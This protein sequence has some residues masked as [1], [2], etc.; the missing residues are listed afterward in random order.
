MKNV[1]VRT[2]AGPQELTIDDYGFGI[3]DQAAREAFTQGQCHALAREINRMTGWEMVGIGDSPD[4]PA[5]VV[6]LCPQLG[7]YVDIYGAT[8]LDDLIQRSGWYRDGI[9]AP[10]L[11]PRQI[12]SLRGYIAPNLRAAAPFAKTVLLE[13]IN[14]EL[15]AKGFPKI[16]LDI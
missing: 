9:T 15:Q 14:P 11:T 6:T 2:Q 10:H 8:W 3:I 7:K 16:S 4:S 13:K 5:H 1:N 12:H